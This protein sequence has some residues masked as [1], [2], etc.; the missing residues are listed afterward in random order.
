[1]KKVISL[2]LPLLFCFL[3]AFAS[4]S[5]VDADIQSIFNTWI[6]IFG[7][8]FV[9]V[10]ML[11]LVADFVLGKPDAPKRLVFVF[12][13][14]MILAFHDT[15]SLSIANMVTGGSTSGT[16]TASYL[17]PF[18]VKLLPSIQ[19]VKSSLSST[20]NSVAMTYLIG[21]GLLVSTLFIMYK[22]IIEDCNLLEEI[23]HIFVLLFFFA[24]LPM[25]IG[26]VEIVARKMATSFAVSSTRYTA[27]EDDFY[28]CA[29]AA[30]NTD[31]VIDGGSAD[32]ETKD[33]E[34]RSKT[35]VANM[36]ITGKVIKPALELANKAG[37]SEKEKSF[38]LRRL[39]D[40]G[41]EAHV[42]GMIL[43]KSL[44]D[45]G[46]ELE[47]ND[48]ASKMNNLNK[49]SRE[50]LRKTFDKLISNINTTQ[51]KG[52]FHSNINAYLTPGQSAEVQKSSL[53]FAIRIAEMYI[54]N[55]YG[56]GFMTTYFDKSINDVATKGST[57]K[58]LTQILKSFTVV[59]VGGVSPALGIFAA[60]DVL[61]GG[62]SFNPLAYLTFFF[63]MIAYCV[64]RGGRIL[65]AILQNV[66]SS[67]GYLALG[68]SFFYPL[69]SSFTRWLS[70]FITICLWSVTFNLV[71]SFGSRL[72][73]ND[74]LHSLLHSQAFNH[75]HSAGI[76]AFDGMMAISSIA[77]IVTVLL[78]ATP[79]ITNLYY[80][81]VGVG[82]EITGRVISGMMG[83][84]A[85]TTAKAAG[86]AMAP[87]RFG[88]QVATAGAQIAGN[89]L[90][91]GVGGA[92]AGLAM[93]PGNAAVNGVSKAPES[94]G[95]LGQKGSTL[96]S[97]GSGGGNSY[98]VFKQSGMGNT[99]GGSNG[100]KKG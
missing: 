93:A 30:V 88:A 51:E 44:Q 39:E 90:A 38:I 40:N 7:V 6:P 96:G 54:A 56:M 50:Q 55:P 21:P 67:L 42:Q 100:Y 99:G 37:L 17:D 95:S 82:D 8:L 49:L 2:I 92:A 45:A 43:Y 58:S 1:M 94:L 89:I 24:F 15:L 77:L 73:T 13:G 74:I 87:I 11:S 5:G 3:P 4:T 78:I 79:M 53:K 10:G 27:L 35:S 32:Y 20:S 29:L 76:L 83:T 46:I 69:R 25:L 71:L 61:M 16:G 36:E 23:L 70:S 59:A 28:V 52:K 48:V 64:I 91:P 81:F 9:V 97:V 19:A 80:N 12:L 34:N 98:K 41:T 68:L 65:L 57:G 66:F 86:A 84:L 33:F 85:G 63:C 60:G 47:G 31:I 26:G 22:I 18:V 14:I 75:S 62:Y 72:L